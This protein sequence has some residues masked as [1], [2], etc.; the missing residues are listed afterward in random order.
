MSLR[1]TQEGNTFSNSHIKGNFH[2][3]FKLLNVP[4]KS[5]N[6]SNQ[7]RLLLTYLRAERDADDGEDEEPEEGEGGGEARVA[8]EGEIAV[9][10][11]VGGR[12]R[13]RHAASTAATDAAAAGVGV[14]AVDAG[15]SA[16][17]AWK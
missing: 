16:A 3:V 2:Y 14:A 12:R 8:A 5:R 7:I 13:E 17:T 4:R 15:G 9:L 1:S 6:L 10:E 11:E